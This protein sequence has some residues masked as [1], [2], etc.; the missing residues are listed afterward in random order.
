MADPSELRS[1]FSYIEPCLRKWEA[2]RSLR[3]RAIQGRSL[4]ESEKVGQVAPSL[5]NISLNYVLL[6]GFTSHVA[7]SG[8]ICTKLLDFLKPPLVAFYELMEMDP[9][10]DRGVSMIHGVATTIKKML[11]AIRAKWQRW[12]MPRAAL[13]VLLAFCL[14]DEGVLAGSN[15]LKYC[16]SSMSCELRTQR[17]KTWSWICQGP[18]QKLLMKLHLA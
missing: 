14:F 15:C 7:S 8:V 9:T 1:R 12:E 16:F 11:T 6:K 4:I 3:K 17:S 18:P 2:P 5:A 10:S 13:L